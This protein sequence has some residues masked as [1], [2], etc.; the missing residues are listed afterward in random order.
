[1][2]EV[3]AIVDQERSGREKGPSVAAPRKNRLEVSSKPLCARLVVELAIMDALTGYRAT[4]RLVRLIIP[5]MVILC[6]RRFSSQ[7]AV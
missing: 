4:R 2:L 7:N 6:S 1:V 3:A 5:T